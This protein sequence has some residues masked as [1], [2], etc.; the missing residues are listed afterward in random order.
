MKTTFSKLTLLIF[1]SFPFLAAAQYDYGSF[2]LTGGAA[3]SPFATDY[4]A[5]GINPSHLDWT[6]NYE[7]KTMALGI[8]EPSVSFYS[9]FLNKDEVNN[10][11]R[12][13][14]EAFDVL[15]QQEKLELAADFASS[16]FDFDFDVMGASYAINTEKLGGFAFSVK[17]RF[18]ANGQFGD[19][20]SELL[21]LGAR[22]SY[23][24]SLIVVN[25]LDSLTIPNNPDDY[26]DGIDTLDVIGFINENA[27]SSISD[28]IAGTRFNVS[29]MT[30]FSVGYGKKIV[31]ADNVALY[32][33]IG[34]KYILGNAYLQLGDDG[35]GGT[36]AFAA[37]SPF[38]N[39]NQDIIDPS[40]ENYFTS[41]PLK[42]VG[43]GFGVDLGL[44]AQLGDD[45][46]ITAAVND[47]GSMTWKG[48]VFKLEDQQFLQFDGDGAETINF[49]EEL[50][51][52]GDGEGFVNWS[53]SE[54]TKTS[55][56]THFR[57][58]IG[59]EVGEVLRLGAEF[60][61][62]F[63]NNNLVYDERIIALGGHLDVLPFVTVSAGALL[64]GENF[65]LPA[66]IVFHTKNGGWEAGFSSRD[67]VT[68]FSNDNPTVSLAMGFTRFRF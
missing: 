68:F 54:K 35:N 33:G 53:G 58:G 30:E 28:L 37:F 20:V 39:L 36:S 8:F 12:G 66:G 17:Q 2:N 41:P 65:K 23:F 44:S 55:L 43:S 31:Q 1:L 38:F 47:I 46:V 56:P 52:L 40:A 6:S 7:G 64:K 25:G 13:N 24:D 32:G 15:T 60:V 49:I 63:N 16:E 45:W 18:D 3:V 14:S 22:A 9:E 29:W 50:A 34:L 67:L 51:N 21:F 10:L 62:P 19:K 61:T 48:N 11:L 27:A 42:P 57:G 5:L 26:P 4:Q 59:A